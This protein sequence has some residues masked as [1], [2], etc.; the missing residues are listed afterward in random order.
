MLLIVGLGNPGKAYEDT[1]HNIGFMLVDR[2]AEACGIKFKA[3][4]RAHWGEGLVAGKKAV[5]IKPQTFMNLC[6]EAV[7]EFSRAC[8]VEPASIIAA[9][10]DCDLPFG[11]IRLRKGG[12]S[13]GHRGIS[14]II[15]HL[16]T[17]EFPRVRLGVG[18]PQDGNI[19]DYVLNP[20][21]PEESLKLEEILKRG[22]DS[23]ETMVAMGIEYAM[24][25]FNASS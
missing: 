4:G 6:G 7:A 13:G 21:T 23:I 14:S 19:V 5:L 22:V 20:F 10:D 3:S 2:V 15:N 11:R 1:R 17:T 24:N 18:R 16:G 25:R 8:S 12:G 9:Y